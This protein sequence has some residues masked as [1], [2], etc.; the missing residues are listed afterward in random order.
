LDLRVDVHHRRHD[1]PLGVQKVR[2]HVID[3]FGEL[4]AAVC[5]KERRTLDEEGLGAV[6]KVALDAVDVPLVDH[7]APLDLVGVEDLS[8]FC[9]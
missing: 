3:I 4:F 1:E 7:G 8:V 6:D 5:L 9:G 2:I